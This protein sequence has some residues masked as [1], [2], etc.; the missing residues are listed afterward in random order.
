VR[1]TLVVPYAERERDHD[2]VSQ[3]RWKRRL[4]WAH[5]NHWYYHWYYHWYPITGT[6]MYYLLCLLSSSHPT[7]TTAVHDSTTAIY[8]ACFHQATPLV[9]PCTITGTT[10]AIYSACFHQGALVRA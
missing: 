9:L 7:G 4:R 3:K 8:S 6:T 10:T 2:L 1:R 5:M